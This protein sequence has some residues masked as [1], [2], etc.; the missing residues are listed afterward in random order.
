[1][2]ICNYA[3]KCEYPRCSHRIPHEVKNVTSSRRTTIQCTESD[4]CKF[5]STEV[6]CVQ[7]TEKC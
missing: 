5:H 2:V 3:E 1:M 6:Q 4:R 7:Y